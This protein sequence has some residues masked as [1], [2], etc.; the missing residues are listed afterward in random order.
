MRSYH[1]Y[2]LRCRVSIFGDWKV[3][4]VTPGGA[5]FF[6]GQIHETDTIVEV[7]GMKP[8]LKNIAQVNW[9][10]ADALMHKRTIELKVVKGRGASKIGLDRVAH[11]MRSAA[12][13]LLK[14]ATYTSA[15][16]QMLLDLDE[17]H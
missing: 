10:F 4:R 6:T 9:I 1:T 14:R 7:D 15:D 8:G 17:E 5:A 11:R 12:N 16:R 2:G 3:T 13:T